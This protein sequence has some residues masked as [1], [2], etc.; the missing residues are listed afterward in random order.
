M[1]KAASQRR[2]KR[3]KFLV[4]LAEEEPERFDYEWEKRMSSWLDM[5]RRDAGRLIG[6]KNEAIP[7]VFEVIT[8][9][10][11]VLGYCG[12]SVYEK[13]AKETFNIL[14]NE[15]CS[16]LAGHIDPRIFRLNNYANFNT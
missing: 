9:A 7:P 13:Y 14:N 11:T 6:R 2:M 8:E 3:L 5:I 15:C 12:E 10:L 4:C 16:R 1:G